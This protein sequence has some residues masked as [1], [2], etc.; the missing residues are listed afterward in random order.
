M[1]ERNFSL[2]LIEFNKVLG[3]CEE[4]D[5]ESSIG[6]FLCDYPDDFD[7][8]QVY[9]DLTGRKD[10]S[11]LLS[12][13]ELFFLWC[14]VQKRKVNLGWWFAIQMA[15]C[16][17]KSRSSAHG[18]QPGQAARP[19]SSMQPETQE[20]RASLTRLEA[21]QAKNTEEIQELKASLV[22]M[23]TH[24]AQNTPAIQAIRNLLRQ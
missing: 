17:S 20:L 4:E 24:Q 23:E 10:S 22:I 8:F 9:R 2:S 11:S 3:F 5:D 16:N 15:A 1:L 6:E 14:M 13:T 7:Q 18:T 21:Q 12:K 19:S